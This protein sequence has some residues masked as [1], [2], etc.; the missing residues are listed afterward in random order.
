[1]IINLEKSIRK[2][3]PK[4]NVKKEESLGISVIKQSNKHCTASK[5]I[6]LKSENDWYENEKLIRFYDKYD[7]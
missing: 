1:L 4:I 5:K 6:C 2:Y 7:N 3:S